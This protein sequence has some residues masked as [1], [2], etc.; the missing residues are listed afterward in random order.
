[1]HGTKAAA[2]TTII[3]I[4]ITIIIIVACFTT[5]MHH[6]Y[7]LKLAMCVKIYFT[8]PGQYIMKPMTIEAST[9]H[10]ISSL[11]LAIDK[12]G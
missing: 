9:G 10:V 1:M 6:V 8:C 7:V 4:I 2:L 11:M 5:I 12:M 3:I